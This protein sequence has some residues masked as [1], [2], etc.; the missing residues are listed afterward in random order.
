MSN[1]Y[2]PA[3]IG[4]LISGKHPP[5]D[6]QVTIITSALPTTHTVAVDEESGTEVA[7]RAC[8]ENFTFFWNYLRRS[9]SVIMI[10]ADGRTA[11]L[12]MPNVAQVFIRRLLKTTGDRRAF[13]LGMDTGGQETLGFPPFQCHAWTL[14][15]LLIQEFGAGGRNRTDTP[16]GTGF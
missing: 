14:V 8:A 9:K 3:R 7:C 5:P 2:A 15:T 4:C 10:F 16:L 6:T 13:A 12:Q 11:I 1:G